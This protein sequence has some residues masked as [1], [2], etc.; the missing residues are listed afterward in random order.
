MK[1][2]PLT[3]ILIGV[4]IAIIALSYGVIMVYMPNDKETKYYETY[5][6]QLQTEADKMTRA[7]A[8]VEK[9]KL[10]VEQKAASW[11]EI[12]AA[13]TP[14]SDLRDG[15]INISAQGWQL[16]V[17]SRKF[18]DSVQRA[19]NAQLHKGGV[20]IVGA[21]PRI[22]DPD[23]NASSILTSY[24]N[25]P[26]LKFPIVIF[27]LGQVTVRGTYKQIMEHV[28][29]FK[30]MPRYLA[31]TDGLAI[32]G[33]TPLLTATYNLTLVGYIRGSSIYPPVPEGGAS[34]NSSGGGGG[35]NGGPALPGPLPVPKGG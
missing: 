5:K 19:L 16:T 33:T 27:D 2:S 12:V 24:Y 4:S 30:N 7:K 20:Q 9:A 3:I 14:S 31:E 17:D 22:P 23:E 21:G 15:G 6:E 10:M 29:S 28:Q 26:A 8:R 1:L 34:A 11:R 18:R 35:R 13:H 32:T 25:Y